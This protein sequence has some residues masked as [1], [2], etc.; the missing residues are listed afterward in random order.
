VLTGSTEPRLWTQPHREL[1]SETSAGF[2]V[3]DWAESAIGWKPMPWQRWALIH[4]LELLEDGTLRFQRVLILVARQSGKTELLSIL[5]LYWLTHGVKLT[6]STSATVDTARES[7]LKACEVAEQYPEVFG[8]VRVRGTNG[9]WALE[10]PKY[11]SRNKVVPTNRSGGRGLSA[12]RVVIDELRQHRDWD[13]V[14]AIESTTLAVLDSQIW[15][16]SNAGDATS[17]VLNR[18][19]Q[20][21]VDGS[22]ESMFLAEWSAPEDAEIDDPE[23]WIA[24]NPALGYTLSEKALRALSTSVPPNIFRTENL[25][26]SIAD[27]NEA[28]S[29]ESWA[30]CYDAGTLDQHRARVVVGVDMSPDGRNIAMVAA[31]GLPDGRIRVE[32]V[33]AWESTTDMRAELGDLVKRIRPVAVAWFPAGAGAISTDLKELRNNR[34]LTGSEVTAA[35]AGLADLVK[36]GRIAHNG[37][38]ML[39]SHIVGAQKISVGD[40]WKFSRKGGW[41]NA[42]YSTAGAVHLARQMPAPTRLKFIAAKTDLKETRADK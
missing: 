34:E 1:T 9:L 40:G 7:W 11:G 2:A 23:S 14:S 4:A 6:L 17:V 8:N 35:C 29:A 25:C 22:D 3:V 41:C 36:A 5:I 28:V 15:Y 31:A 10:V 27:L 38:E 13:A 30:D 20:Q 18:Y 19:R 33:A 21:G 39:T 12:G 32:T 24:A 37:D 16:I 26:Q 42:A